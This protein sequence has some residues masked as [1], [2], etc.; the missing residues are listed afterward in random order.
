M[1]RNLSALLLALLLGMSAGCTEKATLGSGV[2]PPTPVAPDDDPTPSEE[3]D[4]IN[5]P[6]GKDPRTVG[7]GATELFLR[8]GNSNWG[9]MHASTKSSLTSYPDVCAWL[10]AF[11][12]AE[13]SGNDDLFNRLVAKFD[14]FL[15][16]DDKNIEPNKSLV[17]KIPR[18]ENNAVDYNIFGAVPLHIYAELKRRGKPET[19]IAKY[20]ELGL[21]YADQQWE[22]P[23]DQYLK[24][25]PNGR[26][27]HARGYSYQTRLW[28]DDM[29]MITALQSQAY[30][31]TGD[32]KY[33]ERAAREMML[34]LDELPGANS[35]FYHAPSAKFFWGRGNGWMAVGMPEMLRMLP[36]RAEYDSYRDRILAKYKAMMATLS[37]YQYESG[38][39]GQLINYN[40]ADMWEETSGSAMFT[41][42][43]VLG[44]KNG[45]LDAAV[46]GPVARKGWLGLQKYILSN[47][48][49]TNVC[50]GTGA[51]TSYE[52]YRD[53]AKNI[54]D[55]HGQAAL[56]W[57]AYALTELAAQSK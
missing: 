50:T 6:A 55:M 23:D 20:L 43:M 27:Y 4:L 22:L 30:L 40:T 31:A 2:K 29:F 25:L 33:I 1:L 21:P 12:Y 9:D 37:A 19:E 47:Y 26:N 39:W 35:V 51:G 56:L 41:Y 48:E 53:R 42:A 17:T 5:W 34:Y 52:Y 24:N 54:G 57:C 46:Y 36:A 13:A 16:V 18:T 7:N 32:E 8:S 44:V 10:G 14:Q 38:M 45:W 11:W 15:T 3:N 28:I 49:I